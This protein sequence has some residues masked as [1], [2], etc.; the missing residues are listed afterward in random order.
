MIHA[1]V[2]AERLALV[3]VVLFAALAGYA[4]AVPGEH[5]AALPPGLHQPSG[6]TAYLPSVC[7]TPAGWLT[8]RFAAA[9]SLLLAALGVRP[10]RWFAAVGMLCFTMFVAMLHPGHREVGALLVGY[11]VAAGPSAAAWTLG[12]RDRASAPPS[13]FA[14]TLQV[15][16]FAFLIPYSLIGVQRLLEGA[17]TVF[18]D[19]SMV[20][21]V[22]SNSGRNGSFAF[23]L[24][25]ALLTL[26]PGART[27][28]AFGYF[29]A[30]YLEALAPFALFHRGFRR[31][32]VVFALAFHAMNLFLLNIEFVLNMIVVVLLLVDWQPKPRAVAEHLAHG[33]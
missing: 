13:H 27:A 28:L 29:V 12:P 19:D 14:L 31:L 17:P 3:R 8:I 5:L 22:A 33:A 20:W 4:L 11:A 1:R 2:S 10:F 16:S 26:V 7:F 32:I 25:A 6:L 23:T 21:H 9:S 30:T 18:L 15:A 24:G